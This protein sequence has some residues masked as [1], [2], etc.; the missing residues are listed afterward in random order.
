MQ[1]GVE[2][3][4]L[5]VRLG[6]DI[7]QRYLGRDRH[8]GKQPRCLKKHCVSVQLIGSGIGKQMGRDKDEVNSDDLDDQGI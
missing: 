7:A 2:L 3:V 4:V 6:P 1:Q 5:T 8:C